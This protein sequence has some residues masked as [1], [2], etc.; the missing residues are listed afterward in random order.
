MS[1]SL[2]HTH[3]GLDNIKKFCYLLSCLKGEAAK[4]IECIEVTNDNYQTPW[5]LLVSRFQNKSVII[6]HHIGKLFELPSVGKDVQIGLRNLTDAV[7]KHV[8]SLENLGEPVQYWDTLLFYLITKK[9]DPNTQREWGTFF[10]TKT[11]HLPSKI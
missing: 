4:V 7:K 8:R 3:T 5:D 11:Y 6:K 2:V 9:F 10:I 1:T